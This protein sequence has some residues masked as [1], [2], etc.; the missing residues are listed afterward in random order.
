MNKTKL[1]ITSVILTA[2][3]SITAFAGQWKQDSVGWWYQNDDGSYPKNTWFQDTDWKWYYFNDS[4]YMQTAPIVL[5]DGTTYNFA[6]D[7]SWTNRW[8]GAADQK[9]YDR[10]DGEEKNV[11][12]VLTERDYI[13]S[14]SGAEKSQETQ[15]YPRTLTPDTKV[16][17]GDK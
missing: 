11:G 5:A 6:T 16:N 3:M 2:A 12:A 9:Y 7:G 8:A 15:S 13:N 1:L 10:S 14:I 17:F 4:G